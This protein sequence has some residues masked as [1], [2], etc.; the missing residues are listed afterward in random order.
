VLWIAASPSALRN[1][2]GEVVRHKKSPALLPG[3]FF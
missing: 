3:F 1:D 2:G